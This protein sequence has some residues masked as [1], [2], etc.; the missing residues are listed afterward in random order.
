MTRPEQPTYFV[1]RSTDPGAPALLELWADQCE[2]LHNG[3]PN[4]IAEARDCARAMR[5]ET[6]DPLNPPAD[7]DRAVILRALRYYANTGVQPARL[8]E[9]IHAADAL[10]NVL[11]PG[12]IVHSE[13][14]GPTIEE[15]RWGKTIPTKETL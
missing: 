7:D 6:P 15:T 13:R 8:N 9:H 14:I 12:P 1:L 4:R 2:R 5:I 11:T 10:V 3:D